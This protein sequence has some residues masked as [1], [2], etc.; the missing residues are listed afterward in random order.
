MTFFLCRNPI[1]RNK[2]VYLEVNWDYVDMLF[3]YG[4]KSRLRFETAEFPVMFVE[5]SCM[6]S[7]R[8]KEKVSMLS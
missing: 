3:E 5:N 6:S 8:S 2:N 4:M 1:Y 7:S